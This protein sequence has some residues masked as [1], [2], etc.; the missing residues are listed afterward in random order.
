MRIR[1][2]TPV[3]ILPLLLVGCSGTAD[4]DATPTA[5]A[6]V[7]TAEPSA[8]AE[9]SESVDPS[10]AASESAGGSD[11]EPTPA[12]INFAQMMIGH[13]DQALVL[14]DMARERSSNAELLELADQIEAAQGPEIELMSG[15]VVEWGYDLF[16]PAD[17]VG[18]DMPGML[19]QEELDVVAN[20]PEADFDR[21]WLEAMI[22]HHEGA[23]VMAEDQLADGVV[24]EVHELSREI[25]ETQQAEIDHMNSMIEALG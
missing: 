22:A 25:I 13:H 1:R 3:L 14:V 19:T 17:H 5:S 11:V 21:L 12:D 23:V 4:E 10:A 6:T 18:H 2:L 7:E 24:P 15:W 16:D 8:T 20:A 9:P